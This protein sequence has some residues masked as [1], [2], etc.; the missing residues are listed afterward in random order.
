MHIIVQII[1][2]LGLP[3]PNISCAM[4]QLAER[5]FSLMIWSVPLP[6]SLITVKSECSL[7]TN[8]KML[9]YI[10]MLVQG[11]EFFSLFLDPSMTFSCAIFKVCQSCDY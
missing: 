9:I 8:Y 5:F 6:P 10:Y 2:E 7:F 11:N 1:A 4:S 3:L